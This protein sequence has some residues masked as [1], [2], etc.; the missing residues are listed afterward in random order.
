MESSIDNNIESNDDNNIDKDES[1]RQQLRELQS[2]FEQAVK[3]NSIE[4]M[5][6][7]VDVDFSFVS[8]TD[9][10]FDNFDTFAKQWKISRNEMIGSGSFVSQLNPEPAVFEG[11]IAICKGNASNTMVDK[12][13]KTFE[14]SSNWTVVFK[15]TDGVWKVLRAHNSLDPF[16]NPMLR[17][18]VKKHVFK[19]S[20]IAFG[21]GIFSALLFMKLS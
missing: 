19:M 8:F 18:G 12:R 10:S 6:E 4:D 14:Y 9:K 16:S 17:S 13:D 20:L 3:N 21:I 7:H 5:R 1:S 11:D 2:I 15:Q